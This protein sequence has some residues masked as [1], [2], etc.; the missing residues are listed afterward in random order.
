[1]HSHILPGIDDGSPSIEVSL[2]LI[3]GMVALGY[4]KLIATPHVMWDM[5]QNTTETIQSAHRQ[6]KE[7]LRQAGIKVQ[8]G[9]AA[10]YYLDEY[11][12]QLLDTNT[13]LL[14]IKDN[15]VLIEFSFVSS[16]FDIKDILFKLQIKGYQ[17]ILAHPERYL[18]LAG[19]KG[20][21]DELRAAGC[22]F[23]VNLLSLANYYGKG[24][25]ELANYLVK[26]N[27]V[28]LLGTDLHHER[29]LH[30]LENSGTT[31]VNAVQKLLDSGNLI[32]TS[33]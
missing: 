27:Y 33:L 7:A 24:A 20:F 6:L 30:A 11:F 25:T 12:V 22:L 31:L 8:T 21:Y 15:K 19:N 18:Y 13:P 29:H 5:Y 4:K 26:K 16:P 1:M 9:A 2:E 10:E 32:N 28:S 14:T 23:Q 3:R 17:P